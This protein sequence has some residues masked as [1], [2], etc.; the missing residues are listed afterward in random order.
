[1][2]TSVYTVSLPFEFNFCMYGTVLPLV[3]ILYLGLL[4]NNLD[5]KQFANTK[6]DLFQKQAIPKQQ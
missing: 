6:I 4:H 3:C 1:M 5:Y 2:C